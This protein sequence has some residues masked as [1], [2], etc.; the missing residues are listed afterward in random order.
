SRTPLVQVVFALQDAPSR[1]DFGVEVTA[2]AELDTGTSRFDLVLFAERGG[3][4]DGRGL[5]LIGEYASD[6]FDRETVERMLGAFRALLWQ[7]AA[8]PEARIGELSLL[9][10]EERAQVVST[11]ATGASEVLPEVPDRPVHRLFEEREALAPEALAVSSPGRSHG[12]LTYRELERRANHLAHR[13]RRLGV[14]PEVLAGLLL[15]RSPELVV[16]ALATLKAGGAYLPIDPAWPS[17]RTLYIL[18]DAGPR[19]LITTE[20]LLANL[21]G[22]PLPTDRVVLLDGLPDAPEDE[23]PPRVATEPESLAYVIY[24]SGSTGAPKGTELRHRGLS[25]LAAWQRG[26]YGLGPADRLPLV[27]APGFDAVVLEM[28]APLTCGASL[29]VAP[30]EVVLSPAAFVSWAAEHRVSVAFLPTPLAEGVLA[31][32][33]RGTM[34]LRALFTGGDRLRRRPAPDLPFALGNLYGPTESTVVAT[35]GWVEPQGHRTPHIGR[36]LANTRASILDPG[37]G[38]VPA[39]V[40]AELCL[41]GVGLARGYRG[42]PDLTAERFVPDP[43]GGPGERLY[44]TGDLARRLPSGEI[45]FLGRIDRQVKIRGYRIEL[46]EIEAALCRHPGVAEAA[47]LILDGRLA[48]YVASRQEREELEADGLRAFLAGSLPEV[49]VPSSWAFVEA[50]PVTANGKVDRRA[51]ARIEPTVAA[52]AASVPPRTPLEAAVAGVWSALL[53]IEAVGALDDFF[54][55]G[56]HSLMAARLAA[57]LREH[58]GV[59][60]PLGVIFGQPTVA[61][62]AAWIEAESR[63][64]VDGPRPGAG[65]STGETAPLS[66][67]QQ[68]LWFLDRLEPGSAAYNVPVLLRFPGPLRPDVLELALAEVVRRHA[69]L[70]TTFEVPAGA[71][72]PVQVVHPAAGWSL[73]VIDLSGLDFRDGEREAD[74]RAGDEARRPFDLGRGPL[75]RNLLLRFGADDHR[76]LVTMHHIVSDGWSVGVLQRELGALYRA[77]AAG[78]PSPL[79]ELPVQYPDFAVWQRSW[80]TGKELERQ[81]AW[82]RGRLASPQAFE[83]PADRPRPA[84]RSSRGAVEE[85][86]LPE[87]LAAGLERLGRSHGAT[88]FMTLLAVFLALVQRYTAQDDLIVGTPVAGRGPADVE[89]LIGFFVNTLPLRVGLEGEPA[90]LDLLARVRES[91][92]AA[93]A[94][95]DLPFEMLVAEVAQE[96]DLSRNPLFQVIFAFMDGWMTGAEG[97]HSGTAKFDLS[98]HVDRVGDGLRLWLEHS[99]DLFDGAT[100]RRL[101]GHFQRLLESAVGNPGAPVAALPLLTEAERAQLAAWEGAEQRGHP[102]GLLHG[103]FEAQAR[104]TPDAVALVAGETALSYAKLEARSAKL[105]AGLRSLGAGPEVGVAVCLE[106]KADLVVTLLAVL[107]SGSFYVPIDPRYPEERRAFLVEDSGARIVITESGIEGRGPALEPSVEPLPESL[108]YLIYTSGST[109]RPKAVAITHASAV[110][111]AYWAREVF[112]PGELRGV[113]AC[114]AV[115]FDLSVFEIFVTLAWGGAVILVEDALSLLAGPPAQEVTLVNTVPSAMAELLREGALPPSVRTV[116]LA[117]EAL[118]R[119]LS[120]RVYGRPETELY[121]LYGPSED[122]TYSTWVAV[123]RS[124][125]RPPSIGRPVHDTRA[126]VVDRRLERLPVGVPGELCLAGGGLARGYLGRPELTAERFVPDPFSVHPGERMYRTGDLAKLRVDGELDYLGRLDRQVKIRGFRI[127]LGEVESALERLPGVMGAAV[128]VREDDPVGRRLVACLAAE[129][130]PVAELRQALLRTLPEPMVPSAF[131]FL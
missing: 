61:G 70:R 13:L 62:L 129:E 18:K 131:V 9:S 40:P 99:T 124:S 93:Y 51:L 65:S 68:R 38:P 98:F 67:A 101:I 24:T 42:R 49:M 77:F 80:L 6:L 91:A 17:E 88:P 97:L 87:T 113:L 12:G 75:L 59:E 8:R 106:R 36:A 10:D 29:H 128:L 48:A 115:T 30:R 92:L 96:R 37:L 130:R 53:G 58:L 23:G 41:A 63:G 103:L 84:I 86:E 120:D 76:L 43:F 125:E 21:P 78:Q 79:P 2:A 85:A 89:G 122:T 104:R 81:L 46:G 73:P 107:R 28:W 7:A 3:I 20:R 116:N 66:F 64:P 54:A 11:G 56:G 119:A 111:L 16:S 121:N 126:Y 52:R 44:R 34:A 5:E 26:F 123:E 83:L 95:Q 72:D 27:A 90:F 50:L 69:A 31:E 55:L 25:N 35:A 108:A 82:W 71:A 110:K 14:G 118:T 47:V 117:G 33:A 22:V 94:H 105:A 39:G 32:P 100:I 127:E 60:P 4:G 1:P 57:A 109:G 45:E 19:V 102:E 15:E 74:R 112:S 114:T